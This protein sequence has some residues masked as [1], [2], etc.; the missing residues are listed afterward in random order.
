MNGKPV[1]VL[2]LS[3]V[4]VLGA[5]LAPLSHSDYPPPLKQ[6]KNGVESED[7]QCNSDRVH[8]VRPNGDHACVTEK[9]AQ[10]TSWRVVQ[11]TSDA[12][13]VEPKMIELNVASPVEFVD[14]GREVKRSVLQRSPAPWPMYERIMDSQITPDDVGSDGL[15][16]VSSTPHEKYSVN[17]GVGFYIGDWFPTHILDGYK[18]LYAETECHPSGNCGLTIQYVPTT[19]V[20]HQNVTNYDLDVSKGFM[21]GVKYSVEPLD[22]IEDAIE[23]GK[24]IDES[25]HGNYGRGFVNMTRDG[26]TVYAFE[27]GNSLN[28][29]RAILSYQ[30]ND[31][32]NF[33][34]I[35]NYHTLDELLPVFNSI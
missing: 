10:K 24:E 15:A 31:H 2:S 28:H 35:S 3:V 32:V 5:Y 30:I 12:D 1:L 34:V 21:V 18:L 9:T 27:G 33:H 6:I 8:V 7:I 22:E 14:D 25:Q 13:P 4:F 11:K 23:E 26:K 19:F 29:Y 20:L 16:R 17:P